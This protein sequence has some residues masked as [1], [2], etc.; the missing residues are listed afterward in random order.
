MISLIMSV[1]VVTSHIGIDFFDGL[2][3]QTDSTLNRTIY[4]ILLVY[5]TLYL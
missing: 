5:T 1:L 2:S 4:Y 3:V